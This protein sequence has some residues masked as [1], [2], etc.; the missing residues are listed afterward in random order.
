MSAMTN[1]FKYTH[2]EARNLVEFQSVKKMLNLMKKSKDIKSFCAVV[3]QKTRKFKYLNYHEDDID[4]SAY[5]F[6]NKKDGIVFKLGGT[7]IGSCPPVH[8]I[9]TVSGDAWNYIKFRI[10]PLADVS[11]KTVDKAMHFFEN[12]TYEEVGDD[13]H[14]GN[15]GKYKGKFVVIDW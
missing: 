6:V 1:E 12:C 7:Q 3:K 14:H 4:G 2:D 11:K 13:L 15:V 9:P 5:V 10:Q 8:A